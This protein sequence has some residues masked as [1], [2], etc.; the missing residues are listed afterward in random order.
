MITIVSLLLIAHPL[1]MPAQPHEDTARPEKPLAPKIAVIDRL[2]IKVGDKEKAADELA[3][4]AQAVGGY[5]TARDDASISLRVPQPRQAE[6]LAKAASLGLVIHRSHSAEDLTSFLE[7][8]RT[9]LASR[10]EVLERYF[11]VLHTARTHAVTAVE[12]EMT[13]L[14]AQIEELQGGLI[15][16]EHRLAYAQLDVAFEFRDRQAPAN[17]GSSSFPWL[18]TMNLADLIGDFQYGAR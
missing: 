13:T 17:D 10:R 3:A 4:S 6:M 1:E 18:N 8:R 15:F 11:G 9:I 14:I 12:Q 5:F 2:T 16:A 7:E